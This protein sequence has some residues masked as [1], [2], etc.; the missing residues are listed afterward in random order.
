MRTWSSGYRQGSAGAADVVVDADGDIAVVDKCGVV[1]FAGAGSL[2]ANA[3][4]SSAAAVSRAA[5]ATASAPA[6]A[7]LNDGI[8]VCR[9]C[10]T[11]AATMLPS[12]PPNATPALGMAGAGIVDCA[13]S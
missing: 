10:R 7:W 3:G 11:R 6:A 8:A 2:M 12:M 9:I 5:I 1:A 4:C 13:D